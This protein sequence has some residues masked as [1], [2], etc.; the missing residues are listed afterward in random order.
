MNPAQTLSGQTHC[1]TEGASV[2]VERKKQ[3]QSRCVCQCVSVCVFQCVFHW[4]RKTNLCSVCVCVFGCVCVYS[5]VL[6]SW[7]HTDHRPCLSGETSCW[8]ADRWMQGE[9]PSPPHHA[10]LLE[11]TEERLTHTHA[12]GRYR[13]EV[14]THSL[15]RHREKR[16]THTQTHTHTHT[17]ER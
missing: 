9:G 1:R 8:T 6:P 7:P 3:G 12:A 13:R 2:Y 15:Y 11:G 5:P 10:P 14:N 17:A 4:D 16:L